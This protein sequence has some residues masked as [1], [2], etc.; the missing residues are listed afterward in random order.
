MSK[1]MGRE[2]FLDGLDHQ[3]FFQPLWL[4]LTLV[5]TRNMLRL[6]LVRLVKSKISCFLYIFNKWQDSLFPIY[7]SL[8]IRCF[9]KPQF[10]THAEH[11]L[12]LL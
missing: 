7:F 2:F 9:L 4:W 11:S 8:N 1:W 3:L 5:L 12:A 6:F 10:I